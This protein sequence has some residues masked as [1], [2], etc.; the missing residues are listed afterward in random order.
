GE[1]QEVWER[2]RGGEDG[3]HGGPRERRPPQLRHRR[4]VGGVRAYRLRRALLRRP[5]A[6]RAPRRGPRGDHAPLAWR[7]SDLQGQ[8]LLALRSTD[9]AAAGAAA[10]PAD[11]ARRPPAP[12][13]HPPPPQLPP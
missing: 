2:G 8:V 5:R 9:V 11:R 4:R 13:A 10:P 12:V 7:P 3:D 1:G 6:R